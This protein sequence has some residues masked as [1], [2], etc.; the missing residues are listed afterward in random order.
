MV[1]T[2]GLHKRIPFSLYRD[3]PGMNFS[4]L[5]ELAKSPLQFQYRIENPRTTTLPMVLGTA[6]HTAVLEPHRFLVE[7][8]LW[9]ERGDSG[10]VRPRR[11]KDWDMFV[12]ASGGKKIVKA[13]EYNAAMAMRDAVRNHKAAM[14]YLKRGDSEVTML[15]NDAE[16][17]EHCKGR[18]DW[19]TNVEG[20]DVLVGLKTAR[21]CRPIGFGNAAAKLGYHL[22]WAY[23]RDGYEAITGRTARVVEIVVESV[24]PHDVVVYIVPS[25]VIEA[26]RDE[27][28]KLLVQLKECEAAGEWP[29]ASEVEQILSLPSWVYN[30]DNDITDLELEISNGATQE[31]G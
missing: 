19:L 21:D 9:D 10:K 8:A 23:Y 15:W 12:C 18:T 25:E 13:D 5:K 24:A 26:G 4:K 27:Y 28:R 16:T 17:N 29:G 30:A 6:A 22:Q 14:K 20:C 11:G 2:N 7:F 31:T 3:T 1:L